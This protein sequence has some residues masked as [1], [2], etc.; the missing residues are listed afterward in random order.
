MEE[1]YRFKTHDE[2]KQSKWY[3]DS[4]A[5]V[6]NV[7]KGMEACKATGKIPCMMGINSWGMD[8]VLLDKKGACWATL[9]IIVMRWA[10]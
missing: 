3:W 1:I 2:Q 7:I 8:Y 9:R 5:L 4:D 10:C 6:E